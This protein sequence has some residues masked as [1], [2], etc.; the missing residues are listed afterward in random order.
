MTDLALELV[1]L[2]PRDETAGEVADYNLGK[3]QRSFLD[4]DRVV[5]SSHPT[6]C[7]YQ[8]ACNFNLYVKDGI[9]LREEQVGNYPPP[10]DAAVPDPNPRGCQKG[11]CYAQRMY[12]PTRIKYPLKRVGERG[13]GR[14]QRV[15]W[16]QALSEIADVVVDVLAAEGPEVILNAGGPPQ[17]E[18][19]AQEPRSIVRRQ[20]GNAWE[21]ASGTN[22]PR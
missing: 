14:W 22:N 7:W 21:R 11:V 13:E 8:R 9:V 1:G 12:D 3:L 20:L 17:G 5:K 6:N 19:R 10:N 18:R 2:Q 4:W 15:S 16:D